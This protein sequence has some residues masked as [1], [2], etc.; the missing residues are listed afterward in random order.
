MVWTGE[1]RWY[2]IIIKQLHPWARDRMHC[3][4]CQTK[5]L[6]LEKIIQ[7]YAETLKAGARLFYGGKCANAEFREWIKADSYEWRKADAT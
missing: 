7:L 4:W 1:G 3:G 5:R 2:S 6:C